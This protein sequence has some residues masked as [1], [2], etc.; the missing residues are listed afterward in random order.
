MNY[1]NMDELRKE[2]DLL[3]NELIKLV[4]KRFKFIEQAAIIKDDISKI[5]DNERIE[6]IIVR[7]R[8]LAEINDISPDIVEK[9][10]R[11]I[12]ELSIELETEIF[13][14]K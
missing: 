9:L 12:I 7:L 5:R 3:D 14:K 6:A 2:L 1:K 4:S 10:W 11:Y 8:N 13:N